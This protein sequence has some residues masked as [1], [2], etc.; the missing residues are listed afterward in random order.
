MISVK[1]VFRIYRWLWLGILAL[2]RRFRHSTTPD[3]ARFEVEGPSGVGKIRFVETL[4]RSLAV[5]SELAK[6]DIESVVYV[7]VPTKL[8]QH[9]LILAI[10]YTLGKQH[11]DGT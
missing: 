6:K 9:N 7:H 4:N 10:L 5:Q 8:T 1:L 11:H 3:I 2:P